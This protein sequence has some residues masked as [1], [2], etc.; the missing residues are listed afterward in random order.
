MLNAPPPSQAGTVNGRYVPTQPSSLYNRNDGTNVTS[1]GS[2]M[3]AITSTNM[4]L[5][6]GARSLAKAYATAAE[7]RTVPMTTGMATIAEFR[8][9]RQN[10]MIDTASE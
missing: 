10:G 3:P 6:P 8:A 9:Y 4:A 7:L 1:P 5:R 2:M